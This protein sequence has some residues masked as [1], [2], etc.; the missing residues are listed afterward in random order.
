M[1]PA[2]LCNLRTEMKVSDCSFLQFPLVFVVEIMRIHDQQ[3]E[4]LFYFSEMTQTGVTN[5]SMGVW[6]DPPTHTHIQIEILRNSP[7]SSII[8]QGKL[9]DGKKKISICLPFFCLWKMWTNTVKWKYITLPLTMALRSADI[10]DQ[11]GC[12]KGFWHLCSVCHS[13]DSSQ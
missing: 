3:A 11:P 1:N 5:T 4:P 2:L 13:E 9:V 8:S 12:Q 10:T 7:T 6:K